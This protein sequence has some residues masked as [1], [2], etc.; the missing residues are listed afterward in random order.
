MQNVSSFPLDALLFPALVVF[1]I[2][3]VLA[4]TV[5]R[6]PH[7]SFFVAFAKSAIFTLYFA[8]FFDGTFTFLDDWGYFE[9]GGVLLSDGVSLVNFGAHLPELFSL[10]GGKH[11]MYYLYNADSFRVFGQ[12]YYAPVAANIILTFVAAAFMAAAARSGVQLSQRL[13]AGFFVFMALHPD[14]VAWSTI[15]N[16]KD[17]LVLTGTSVAVY[18]ASRAEQGR[19]PSA[20]LL[21]TLCG[22]VLFFTRFYV[23]L[24]LLV[25]LFGALL[26]S[27]QGRR[28]PALWLLVP[29]GLLGV[30]AVFGLQGL[31]S[32]Y[33][34]LQADFVNPLY[35]VPRILLTPVPFH[36]TVHYTFLNLPQVFQW[37]MMPVLVYGIIRV[38]RRATMTAR[39]VVIYFLLM[40][41]LYGMFGALQGPRHRVQI[42]GL[43]ALFQFYGALGLLSQM[44]PVGRGAP[45]RRQPTVSEDAAA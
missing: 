30:L 11:F 33:V 37:A 45:R 22:L 16:G 18:A 7:W 41:L 34:R 4:L 29:V 36:T 12:A 9:R 35:G 21:A 38:W 6:A 32:A 15:M 3:F 2:G 1:V 40:I 17:I 5:S 31:S 44:V 20:V 23:P 14:I 42:D 24:M 19:Y 13:A 26:L 43:L 25:A 28:S 10:A 27:P 8:L 39:F